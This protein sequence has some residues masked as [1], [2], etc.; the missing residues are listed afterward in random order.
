MTQTPAVWIPG[1]Q[2][3]VPQV[4]SALERKANKAFRHTAT[5]NEDSFRIDRTGGTPDAR[6]SKLDA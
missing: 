6:P 1:F 2:G 3:P 5:H 4:L